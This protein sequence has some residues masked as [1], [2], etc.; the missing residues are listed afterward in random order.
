MSD[1]IAM[2]RL[3][4]IYIV[5]L[6]SVACFAHGDEILSTPKSLAR[7]GAYYKTTSFQSF[8]EAGGYGLNIS[9]AGR[10]GG[11]TSGFYMG[12]TIQI[13][14]F[15]FGL[16]PSDYTSD[17]IGFGFLPL[18]YVGKNLQLSCPVSITAN[19]CLPE[20]MKKLIGKKSI[21]GIEIVPQIRLAVI[22]V[23][24]V[25]AQSF[26]TGSKFSTGIYLGLSFGK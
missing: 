14:Q 4:A 16:V 20:E 18:Y 26:M 7:I 22:D 25:F 9:Y 1:R 2:K 10:V 8:K 6:I 15:N 23:G 24:I 19:V 11:E 17:Q 12:A 5:L 21:W 13:L 3:I